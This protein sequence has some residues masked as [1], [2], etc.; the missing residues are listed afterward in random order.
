MSLAN[1]MSCLQGVMLVTLFVL[2]N[3]FTNWSLA[4]QFGWFLA[5]SYLPLKIVPWRCLHT[6]SPSTSIIRYLWWNHRQNVLACLNSLYRSTIQITV[7]SLCRFPHR[8]HL[9]HLHHRNFAWTLTT[10]L[11]VPN[12]L[13]D[14]SAG[15]FVHVN[16]KFVKTL[17]FIVS[18]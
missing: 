6:M 16:A 13:S 3:I 10:L 7:R 5:F 12:S 1:L 11:F 18:E 2:W 4:V 14:A 8:I 15:S 9:Q 17:L